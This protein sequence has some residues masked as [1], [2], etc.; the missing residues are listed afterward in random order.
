MSAEVILDARKQWSNAI[1][2]YVVGP[3]PY[4]PYFKEYII[5][6]WK[7]VEDFSIFSMEN[8]FYVIKFCKEQDYVNVLE[9]GP[10][11][12]NKKLLMMKR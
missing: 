11:Y 1:V 10:Y 12:Y 4:Y 3:K 7:P 8:G 9:D 2:V 5:R 6:V